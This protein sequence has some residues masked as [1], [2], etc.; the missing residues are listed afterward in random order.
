M[1]IDEPRK[2]DFVVFPK[3]RDDI[4]ELLIA[5]HLVWGADDERTIEHLV[6]LQEKVNSYLE[7][8]GEQLQEDFPEAEGRC[9]VI[10]LYL[11]EEPPSVAKHA[12]GK[13]RHALESLGVAFEYQVAGD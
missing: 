5:D 1:A 12:I 7:Y 2:I 13:M 4:V 11:M 10:R 9:V 3:G 6:L 8:I